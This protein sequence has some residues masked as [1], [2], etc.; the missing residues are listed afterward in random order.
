[1]AA[2]VA[3]TLQRTSSHGKP[4]TRSSASCLRSCSITAST[5]STS[6]APSDIAD[7]AAVKVA[8]ALGVDP[9]EVK[10]GAKVTKIIAIKYAE[11]EAPIATALWRMDSFAHALGKFKNKFNANKAAKKI[12]PKIYPS[13]TIIKVK[14][15]QVY[16]VNFLYQ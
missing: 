2:C 12:D 10:P 5:S 16:L 15:P 6:S 9:A 13:L 4:C 14:Q 11:D 3:S 7:I 8:E 1:M